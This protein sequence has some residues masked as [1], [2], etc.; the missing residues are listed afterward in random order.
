MV[1]ET[2]RH[3]DPI[4]VYR[5]FRDKG[6]LAPEGLRYVTSW[7]RDDVSRCYQV[8]E[9]EHPALLDRWMNNWM[10]IVDF[11]VHPVITSAEA[12]EKVRPLL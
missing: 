8:M 7:I 12:M 4:P 1:I 9:T 3:G 6:R 2:F 11:E 10:D 5:R